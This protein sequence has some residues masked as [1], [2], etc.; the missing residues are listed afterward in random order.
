MSLEEKKMTI[1]PEIIERLGEEAIERAMTIWV[2]ELDDCPRKRWHR[3]MGDERLPSHY[4]HVKGTLS[5]KAANAIIKGEPIELDFS[6]LPEARDQIELEL[7]QPLTNLRRWVEQTEI[8]LSDVEIELKL[9]LPLRDGYVLSGEIDLLTPEWIIDF[10]SGKKRNSQSY[11]IQLLAY[12][13]MAEANGYGER[14]LMNVFLGGEKPVEFI[15]YKK[16]GDELNDLALL[17]QLIHSSIE[18][19]ELILQG[20][21]P[22]CKLGFNC[23]YCRYRAICRGV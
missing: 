14:K 4:Y 7:Q 13:K 16:E 21:K 6:E 15:P 11:R 9:K 3:I 22:P 23:V 18:N 1:N 8:D 10:K 12:K 17:E 19:T 2:T 20:I 5:H